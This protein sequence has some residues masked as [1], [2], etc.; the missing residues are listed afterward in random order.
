MLARSSY[1]NAE[2]TLGFGVSLTASAD[3]KK[4]EKDGSDTY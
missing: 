4:E 2:E 1:R 3:K